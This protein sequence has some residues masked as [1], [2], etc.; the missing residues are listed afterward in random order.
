MCKKRKIITITVLF[1]LGVAV[2]Y[3]QWGREIDV[4]GSMGTSSENFHEEH[5]TFTLNRLIITDKEK[6]AEE[7]IKKCRENDFASTLF[8]YDVAKPNALYGTVYRSRFS[9]KGQKPLF[10]FRYTQTADTLGSYNIVDDPEAFTLVI[11]YEQYVKLGTPLE[12]ADI[13]NRFEIRLR[14]ERA[15]YAVRDLLTY[16]DAEQTAFSI[17]NQYV[18]FVDEEPDKRKNDWKLNERWAWF[19]GDNR[20]SLK[21]TTKPEPYTLDRTLRWVQRQVAPTLKMLKKID[22]G[23]G[24][25]YMETIEQQAKLTEK[26]EMIIKQQTTPAKDLVES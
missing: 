6:C 15:Y 12:E 18:R 19:I 21:L 1:V 16:Y 5:V 20:Q 13:I 9:M 26:H 23:N 24:T 2:S 10:H 11:E 4:V 14:N 17:I 3:L 25:D 8:S 7:I 22:K